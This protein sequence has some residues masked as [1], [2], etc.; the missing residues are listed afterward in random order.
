MKV[1]ELIEE[2]RQ[3]DQEAT[4]LISIDEEGNRKNSLIEVGTALGIDEGY[5]WDTYVTN[6]WIDSE[7]GKAEGYSDEDRAP[8]DAVPVV[9]LWP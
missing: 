9:V 3:L 7:Q 5:E 6:E 4:V 8:E 1:S 2:L